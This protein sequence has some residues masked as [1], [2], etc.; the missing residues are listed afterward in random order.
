M[1]PCPVAG[2]VLGSAP[3]PALIPRGMGVCVQ[4]DPQLLADP[5]KSTPP[6]LSLTP[7]AHSLGSFDLRDMET[8]AFPASPIPCSLSLPAGDTGAPGEPQQPRRGPGLRVPRGQR[9]LDGPPGFPPLLHRVLRGARQR[10]EVPLQ[11]LHQRRRYRS[12]CR[13]HLPIAGLGW[14]D[15]TPNGPLCNARTQRRRHKVL[16]AR[17][18]EQ[19]LATCNNN[20]RILWRL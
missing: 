2:S 15:V 18:P 6:S 16:G 3:Q 11:G 1:P 7:W 13:P 12:S 5:S 20:R 17:F 8:A 14:W 4:G 10:L 9:E 19:L